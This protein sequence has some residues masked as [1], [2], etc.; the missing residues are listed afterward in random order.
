MRENGVAAERVHVTVDMDVLDPGVHARRRTLS[1]LF[2]CRPREVQLR[3]LDVVE[4]VP[5]LGCA[6]STAVVRHRW[7]GAISGAYARR[8]SMAEG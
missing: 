6:T 3:R 7:L 8:R 4:L 5:T 1:A 2:G